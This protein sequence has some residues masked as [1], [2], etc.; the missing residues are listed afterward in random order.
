VAVLAKGEELWSNELVPAVELMLLGAGVLLEA[1]A[2]MIS[3]GSW[4]VGVM[5]VA[6]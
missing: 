5:A 3:K 4:T 2:S 6:V 1:A